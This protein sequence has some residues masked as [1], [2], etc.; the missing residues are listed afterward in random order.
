MVISS[1][2][3]NTVCCFDSFYFYF[4]PL[5]FCNLLSLKL[6]YLILDSHV[7]FFFLLDSYSHFFRFFLSIFKSFLLQLL[8]WFW[9]GWVSFTCF[10]HIRHCPS[11]TLWFGGLPDFLQLAH[12]FYLVF[13]PLYC[14][15]FYDYVSLLHTRSS[16]FVS[17]HFI[18]FFI[19]VYISKWTLQNNTYYIQ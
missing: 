16:L 18:N 11:I 6:F 5:V 14:D 8:I 9:C 4:F 13:Y 3:L 17:A 10:T 7:N 1:N 12:F 2:T 15:N 19:F